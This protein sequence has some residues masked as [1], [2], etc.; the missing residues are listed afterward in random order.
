MQLYFALQ[1]KPFKLCVFKFIHTT[2]SITFP[3]KLH[4]R[5]WSWSKTFGRCM[6]HPRAENKLTLFGFLVLNLNV[7]RSYRYVIMSLWIIIEKW[8]WCISLECCYLLVAFGVCRLE[9]RWK[10][11]NN[12][13]NC[14]GT[15]GVH[16]AF[17]LNGLL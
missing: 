1:N 4:S 11:E 2:D 9:L 5:A 8:N 6:L 17:M 13:V 12:L 10:Y 15:V 3:T 14:I 16:Y 7:F